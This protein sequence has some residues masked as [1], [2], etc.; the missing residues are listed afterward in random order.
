MTAHTP[1][2]AAAS[3]LD[4]IA[5]RSLL[6]VVTCGS[7][8][9]GKST[10]IGRLLFAGAMLA[11]DQMEALRRESAKS[12]NVD[13][14]GIDV[15]LLLDGLEAERE[16]GITIDAAYR[17]FATPKRAF[18]VADGPGHEQY[19]RNMATAAST[20]EAAIILI[21]ARQGVLRQTRR[22]SIILGLMG[23]RHVV[24]AIN[25]MDLVGYDEATFDRI[26]AD[27]RAFLA[28][29][30]EG[31]GPIAFDTVTP[32]PVSAREGDNVVEPSAHM[33]WY[34]G[35]TLLG[36]LEELDATPPA[37]TQG[38][39]FGV[40]WVN[41]PHLDFRGF[42]GTVLAGSVRPGDAVVAASSGRG[43]NVTRIVTM[44]G[45]LGEAEAGDAVTLTLDAEIDV[46]RGDVLCAAKDRPDVTD[47]FMANLIWTG[48]EA[49]QPGRQYLLKIG[50]RT[51]PA[52]VTALK[53]AIDVNTRRHLAATTLE[54]NDIGVV[55]VSTAQG[56]PYAPYGTSREMGGFI[57]IDR[58][59]NATLGAGMIVHGLRRADNVHTQATTVDKAARG[60][61]KGQRPRVLWFT[62]LSGSGKSTIA[63]AVETRLHASGHHT[64]LLDGDNVRLGLNR[65]LGFKEEDRVENIRRVS[66]VARLMVDAGLIVLVSFI[67]PYRAE[68]QFARSLFE[69]GEFVE[70]FVDTPLEECIRR[71]VKGLYAKAQAGEITNFTGISAPYETPENAE[72]VLDTMKG[73]TED[74]AD[75]VLR[76][77][78]EG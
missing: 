70:V 57:L 61:A 32:I 20:A 44:A 78:N 27:Y 52:S 53:H 6:R 21:D 15:S 68:R 35:P 47:Q 59:T 26:V 19:T 11:D 12:G 17:F 72:L 65:D 71:D 76:Q 23:V 1:P 63:N 9:D 3:G 38:F 40:Q 51:V 31:D 29:D 69:A 74:M 56:V 18:I 41:R 34:G 10:L 60:R 75:I 13:A 42:S 30:P 66:E 39:R 14:S 55:N 28:E 46:S 50:A 7:V 5:Q 37:S 67:S 24:L 54:L 49:L 77:L 36:H 64:Y 48:D 45:D 43:A 25:K 73:T 58:F 16:Q 8:D 33:G 4:P 2:P 22:H 62:G